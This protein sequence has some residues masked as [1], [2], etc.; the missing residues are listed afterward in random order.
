M[1]FLD[2]WERKLGWMSFPGLLRYFALLHVMVYLLQYLNPQIGGFLAFDLGKILTGEV[3]RVAT[4][5][6]SS[7]GFGGQG[8]LT[9]LFLYFMVVIAFLSS[10]GLE[11]EWGVFRTS[12]FCY[13]GFA[14]LLLANVIYSVLFNLPVPTSGS[15]VFVSAFFAFATIYPKVELLLFFVLPVEA[16]WLALFGL[17]GIFAIL[18]KAPILIGFV[19]IAFSNYLLWA[20]IPAM[21]GQ[22]RVIRSAGRKREFRKAKPDAEDAFH[23]CAKCGRT[24]VS[25]PDLEFRMAGDGAEYCTDHLEG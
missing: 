6:L 17:F 20:G 23:R 18:F 7:S 2:K 1:Q 21:R 11:Q 5:L 8:G 24:E 25:D 10:D 9:V 15:F 12:I 19:L 16:R 3:W 4:F 14:A 13:I 22:A